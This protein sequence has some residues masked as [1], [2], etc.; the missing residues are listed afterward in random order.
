MSLGYFGKKLRNS[1]NSGSS[2]I[3]QRSYHLSYTETV[4]EVVVRRVV[5]A[6]VDLVQEGLEN[7]ELKRGN[8]KYSGYPT[9]ARF[10]VG[11]LLSKCRFKLSVQILP[12]P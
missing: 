10:C 4:T 11:S 1:G 7:W 6:D 9:V 3:N 8:G 5:V 12:R 2:S